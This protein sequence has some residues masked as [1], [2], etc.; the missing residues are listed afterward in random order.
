MPEKK[1]Q[2]IPHSK[3]TECA[4]EMGRVPEKRSKMFFFF[5]KAFELKLGL[6]LPQ[7]RATFHF[8]EYSSVKMHENL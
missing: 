7:Q 3:L 8:K 5:L 1:L 2:N 4:S 6:L